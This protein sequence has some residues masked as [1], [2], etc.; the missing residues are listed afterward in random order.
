MSSLAAQDHWVQQFA[1]N[2]HRI[3]IWVHQ[4]T[5]RLFEEA[6]QQW[7]FGL[8]HGYDRVGSD[9]ERE[10][11]LAKAA[12]RVPRKHEPG[13]VARARDY[14]MTDYNPNSS[15]QTADLLYQKFKVEQR[16]EELT[17]TGA[18]GTGTPV[19]RRVILE[20]DDDERRSGPQLTPVQIELLYL[21]FRYRKITTKYL[22]TY[23]SPFEDPGDYVWADG[24][25][26]SSWSSH[27]VLTRRLASSGPNHQNLPSL[28]KHIYQPER[29]EDGTFIHGYAG[30]DME[31]MHPRIFSVLW[32]ISRL[33][34]AFANREDCYGHVADMIFPQR[35]RDVYGMCWADVAEKHAD[36]S[37]DF[38]KKPKGGP[39]KKMRDRAKQHLLASAYGADKRT[40]LRVM[41]KAENDYGELAMV[42]LTEK[43]IE[44]MDE[45][46]HRGMPEMEAGWR[47]TVERARTNG[48]L[49]GTA[50]WLADPLGGHRRWFHNG[51][52][53]DVRG[54]DYNDVLNFETLSAEAAIMHSR[55]QKLEAIFPL[56]FE[57]PGT[58]IFIQVHDQAGIELSIEGLPLCSH[59]HAAA[60]CDRG[61]AERKM[62]D[63]A[64]VIQETLGSFSWKG[65]PFPAESSW[66]WDLSAA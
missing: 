21:I 47:D 53:K 1:V 38:T 65:V 42:G 50:P 40:R 25:V 56:F 60:L 11:A 3:G 15:Q 9:W 52:S 23:L 66:G 37:I 64:L 49:T 22:G 20:N 10:C 29:L 45:D 28:M 6:A 61:T 35:R 24:R 41:R 2:L 57:G 43:A 18:P 44:M 34:E 16:P 27:T 54:S 63:T 51:V 7:A 30:A 55:V 26:R 58:G 5:R 62:Q 46:M 14:G 59:R 17:D 19:L 13:I 36:G 32:G 33:Q 48:I 8:L 31:Q 4:P 39:A 12:N